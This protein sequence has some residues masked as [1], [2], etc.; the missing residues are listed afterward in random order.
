V[1]SGRGRIHIPTLHRGPDAHL[2]CN[3]N[4]NPRQG[5]GTTESGERQEPAPVLGEKELRSGVERRAEL[6]APFSLPVRGGK[7]ASRDSTLSLTC[8]PS[9]VGPICHSQCRSDFDVRGTS[10]RAVTWVMTDAVGQVGWALRKK[11]EENL[12]PMLAM[13]TNFLRTFPLLRE[14]LIAFPPE[15]PLPPTTTQ[16]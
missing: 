6:C 15:A 9:T 13:L 12:M 7:T 2:S 4:R 5:I 8:G 1:F 11:R 14:A 16:P 3:E 10:S